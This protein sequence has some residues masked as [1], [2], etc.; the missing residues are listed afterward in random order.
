MEKIDELLNYVR[1]TNPEMTKNKLL[2]ELFVSRC[3]SIGLFSIFERNKI[4]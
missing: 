3:S 1:K 2:E 4:K